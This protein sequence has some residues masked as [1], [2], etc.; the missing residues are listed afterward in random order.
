MRLIRENFVWKL[1]SLTA[2]IALW[3]AFAGETE[4][5]TSVPVNVQYRHVPDNVEVSSDR[6]DRLFLKVRG[7]VARLTAAN[8]SESTLILDLDHIELPGDHTFTI[9]ESN[10]DLPAG[11]SLVRVVPSQ[12]R[13]SIDR[14]IGKQVPVIEQFS[15]AP[16]AGY[17]VASR[18]ISP[19][20]V[21]IV[22]PAG[23][24][25]QISAAVT[26]PIDLGSTIAVQQF[27]VNAYL[28]DPQVQFEGSPPVVSVRVTLEKIP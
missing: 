1:F 18:E 12:V 17:R 27:K 26:D 20:S 24:V 5:A 13:I 21:R 28:A 16:P 6:L 22:G 11:I 14:R 15:K 25:N 3:I 10:L 7:P 9:G 2:S 23:R 19:E 8:L 4:I